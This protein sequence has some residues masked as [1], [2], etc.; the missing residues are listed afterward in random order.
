MHLAGKLGSAGCPLA[1]NLPLLTMSELITTTMSELVLR[2]K[3]LPTASKH[4]IHFL[5]GH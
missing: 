4:S 2:Q 3:F 1:L 5:A